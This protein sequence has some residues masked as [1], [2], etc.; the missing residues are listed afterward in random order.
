MRWRLVVLP[1]LAFLTL[2]MASVFVYNLPPVHDRIA[3]RVAGWGA[4]V[5]RAINPP[6]KVVF[7]PEGGGDPGSAQ[8]L[9]QSTVDAGLQ[10][11]TPSTTPPD[12]PESSFEI[13][14]PVSSPTP[15]PTP[16]PSPTF[17]PIPG[18]TILTGIVH[19]YQTF[20][21]CGPANVAMALSY[22]GWQGDQGVTRAFLRPNREVDDKNVMPAE[23][24]AFVETQTGLRALT[25]VGGDPDLL[26]RL[27]AAG[28]PVMIEKGHHPPDDWWMGHFVVVSG[29]DDERARFITQDSLIM[30]DLPFSYEELAARWWR[31]F[32]YRYLVF[33][34]M[35]REAELFA[36]LGPHV[37][38][39]YNFQHAAQKARDDIAV[40]GGR[41][42]F[43]AW[44][45]LGASLAGLGD[46]PGAAEA[47]DQAFAVYQTL[48]ED[49]RPY[50]LMWYRDEPYVAYYHTGRYQDVI[51]LANATFSWVG[52]PVLEESYYWRGM[53]Y[54]ALGDM[55]RAIAD[56]KK[57]ASLNQ[58]FAPAWDELRRLGVDMP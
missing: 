56:L 54:Q 6:E 29:Y 12:L 41:D 34:P 30:P 50:R 2:C 17:T 4:Q 32:N 44:F 22:W 46:Y 24:V 18:Q 48:P 9:A 37:D 8:S 27:I 35:E 33:Y 49:L 52:Q 3:W 38:Q 23:M 10:S 45:N 39:T 26:K 7:V 36:I 25:R 40:L 5:R 28:F 55:D 47:F 16:L 53:A 20:N 13:V 58:N 42:S 14:E 11:M 21:N 15:S 51:D 1:L 19:E 57:A 31:D 43:F